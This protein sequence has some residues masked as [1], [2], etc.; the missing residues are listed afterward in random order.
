MAR[1]TLRLAPSAGPRAVWIVAFPDVQILDVTGPL[2][3]F[4]IA[5]RLGAPGAPR[6]E[7][8]LAAPAPGPVLTSSGVALVATRGL[9]GTGP[10]DTLIVAG[11]LGTRAALRDRRLVAWIRRTARRA[12]RVASVCTGA[13]L[14]GEAGLIDGRR[15]TTHW[16]ACGGLE[17]RFPAAR[18]ERD[19]IFVR[20]G[21]VITSAGIT[22][23]I[24]LALD[25]V[26]EDHGRERALTVA[27]W[28][29]M[30]LRRPGGQSQF[31]VQLAGQL[32]ER[33]GVRDVQAWVAEHVGPGLSVSALARRARMSPRNFARV[34]RREVGQTPAAFVEAQRV[35]TARRLLETTTQSVAEVAAQCGF[36]R[37]ET[38]HRAFQR[39][40]RVAPAQYRR[41]FRGAM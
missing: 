32:A 34:F 4:S 5:N 18:V 14:L 16:Y 26:E 6:Y 27:R 24:D 20:D 38:M 35:E 33:D 15:V 11:G 36:G 19:P 37:V 31:S 28:L 10:I 25:L 30:Y 21:N 12:R 41:H 17:R 22:A 7:V 13:F 40:L 9:Q 3:V 29:V 2:E 8:S 23:G 39:R 1:S